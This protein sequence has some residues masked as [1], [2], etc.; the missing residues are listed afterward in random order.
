[1][2]KFF[3]YFFGVLTIGTIFQMFSVMRD[4]QY[5]NMQWDLIPMHLGFTILLGYLTVKFHY[6]YKNQSRKI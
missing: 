6:K 4:P 3:K 5:V 2:N 1:M